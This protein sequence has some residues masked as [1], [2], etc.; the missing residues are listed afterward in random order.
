LCTIALG[1]F[2]SYENLAGA[3]YTRQ[4]IFLILVFAFLGFVT[5]VYE[6]EILPKFYA[7]VSTAIYLGSMYIG[8]IEL[9]LPIVIIALISSESLM[10]WA[11]LPPGESYFDPVKKVTF[12]TAQNVLAI[13]VSYHIFQLVGGKTVPFTGLF[14]Y[15][16]PFVAFVAY[17]L[18]NASLV[19]AIISLLGGE[20]FYYRLKFFLR[21]LHIQILSLGVLSIL[22][23]VVYSS[24]PWNVALVGILLF[25]VNHS[26]RSYMLLRKQAKQTFEKIMDLLS[27]RDPYTH[28]HSESV[29]D[30]TEAIAEELKITPERKEDIV[31]AARVHDI[32]KLGIP[33]SILLKKGELNEEEWEIMKEHPVVGADILSGLAIYEDASE[34]VR[35]EHERWDGSGYP[36]GIEGE[37]IPLGSRIVAVADVWNALRTKRPY[38][39]PLSV[40]AA[41]EEIKDMAGVKL[42]PEVVDA[43]LEV[44]DMKAEEKENK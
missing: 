28:E 32:G 2:V 3:I 26:M 10:R 38:R 9:A 31:S 11:S 27:K 19:S 30:L 12:N 34:V 6:V 14:F 1:G 25:L 22:I 8:G 39:G 21:N 24:S 37:D 16:P 18:V 20:S 44:I 40:D 33:D 15:L 13:A 17:V 23:A 43:L 42:D 5:E 7:S 29:G 4:E 41:K 35:Y 36:E